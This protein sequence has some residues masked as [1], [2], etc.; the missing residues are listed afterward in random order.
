MGKHSLRA[1]FG[2]FWLFAVVICL[3]LAIVMFQMYEQGAGFQTKQAKTAAQTACASIAEEY[4]RHRK[5]PSGKDDE[6][7][8]LNVI[9][10]LVLSDF[11]GVEGGIWSKENE[12]IAYAYPTYEGG[13]E[14]KDV[15]EAEK[16]NISKVAKISL[17]TNAPHTE[18]EENKRHALVYSACPLQDP[19]RKLVVWSMTRAPADLGRVYDR[20]VIGLALLFVFVLVSGLWLGLF[21]YRWSKRLKALHRALSEKSVDTLPELPLTGESE[22][23]T[24]VTSINQFNARLRAA[25]DE[26]S[27]LGKELAKADRLAALGRMAAAIA[28]EIRNPIAAMR[29]KAENALAEPQKRGPGALEAI[30]KQIE[31][32]DRILN[33]IL[34][35]TQSLEI[36]RQKVNISAWIEER[37]LAI[38]DQADRKQV[39]ITVQAEPGEAIFDPLH[40]GRALDNLLVNAL[41]FSPQGGGVKI[42]VGQKQNCLR[43]RVEDNGPGIADE[44]RE[45]LFEPFVSGRNDGTGLGLS[46][47]REVVVA[48]GGKVTFSDEEQLTF[49]EME[50]PWDAS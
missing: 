38:R 15:P 11:D 43:I 36:R 49:F 20:L 40:L 24:I 17:T 39:R 34:L 41:Y 5:E 29:L 32:L 22:L 37:I 28:H 45:H 10:D 1:R 31:R 48:H 27:Q 25:R 33:S 9:L 30:L 35:M 7:G 47:V 42:V 18:L 46:L 26:S 16:G 44:I 50:I 8:F 23:D 4:A 13:K 3:S 12:F 2:F 14:K 19:T 6:A 21:L